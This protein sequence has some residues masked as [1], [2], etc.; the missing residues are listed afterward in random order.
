M[1]AVKKAR[2]LIETDPYTE[3]A[4]TL[5]ALVLSLEA[6]SSFEMTR[7]YELG[8]KEFDLAIDILKEWRIDR[9]YANK[10]KLFDLSM[11]MRDLQPDS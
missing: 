1:N 4:K 10:V 8:L 3:A 5:S 7:L 11:M 2:R 9:Y 6:A